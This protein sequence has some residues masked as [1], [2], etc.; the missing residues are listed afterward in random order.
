MSVSDADRDSG[1]LARVNAEHLHEASKRHHG[2]RWRYFA[3]GI[4]PEPI[5]SYRGTIEDPQPDTVGICCSGGGVRS[6]AFN[7]GALQAVD[8]NG[9]L[10]PAK[11]LAAVSGGSYIAAALSMVAKAWPRG[12]TRPKP[13]PANPCNGRDDSNPDLIDEQGPFAQGSP[14]EQYLRNRSSYLAPSTLDKLYLG[15]RLTL[16]V[17]F[18]VGF[19]ALP[20]VGIGMLLGVFVYRPAFHHLLGHCSTACSAHLPVYMWLP[21]VIVFGA[22]ALLGMSGLLARVTTD[23]RRRFFEV[24][25]TRLFIASIAVGWV[26]VILPVLVAALTASGSAGTNPK[27]SGIVGGGGLVG[28][29]AGVVAQLREQINGPGA[30]VKDAKTLR[31]RY[32][33]LSSAARKLV[34]YLVAAVVG[35]ALLLGAMVFSVSLTLAHSKAGSINLALV[36]GGI[37]ALAAFA[38]AYMAVDLTSWSLHPFYRRRLCTAF[39]LK[40]VKPSDLKPLPGQRAEDGY[41]QLPIEQAEDEGIAVERN[42]DTLVPLSKTALDGETWPTLIV[43]AAAN[44]SNTGATPPGRRVTSFTFSANAIG[45]PLVG[46]VKTETFEDTFDHSRKKRRRRDFTLPAAVAMSGAALSPSMG[47]MTRRPLTFLLA[48]ANVRLGVW[49]P[50]PRWV[51]GMSKSR[52]FW[53]GRARPSYLIRELIGWNRVNARYLYVSDGGHYENLGLVEL[54]RRGCTKIYCFDASGGNDLKELGDAIALARSEL[55]VEMIGLDPS[56][57]EPSAA[58]LAETDVVKC[59][60]RYSDANRTEGVLVYARNVLTK[61]VPWDVTAYHEEDSAFPNDPTVDQ[62]YTDQRFEAYRAL[63]HGAGQRAVAAMREPLTPMAPPP[64]T[65][66]HNGHGR[67]DGLHLAVSLWRG[68]AWRTLRSTAPPD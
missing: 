14:E 2:D 27:T 26:T 65:T 62:L 9:E 19:L 53:F 50:N 67:R 57:L 32:A 25:S 29:L 13:D 16:G 4:R 40:R 42:Y 35:P 34:A 5:P 23:L 61:S 3:Y 60:F 48:L 20:L 47:K 46:G 44:I 63:G 6:A 41:N 11:Y 10:R 17:V 37:G 24:W 38:I 54:L 7:L 59:S 12:E 15:Y 49:V 68:R 22:S 55:R 8:E 39:A 28:L 52:W 43:C 64:L 51:A 36:G 66:A 45:G 33:K 30:A 56:K 58:G 18:N 1:L 31:D 21:P